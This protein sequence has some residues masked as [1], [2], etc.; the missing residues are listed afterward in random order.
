[1]AHLNT[2]EQSQFQRRRCAVLG[3]KGV[4]QGGA[5]AEPLCPLW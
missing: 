2:Y 3:A 5:D 1:M 4:K